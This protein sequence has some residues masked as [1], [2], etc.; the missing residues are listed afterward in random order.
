MDTLLKSVL[1]L[2]QQYQDSGVTITCNAVL[3]KETSLTL[4]WNSSQLPTHTQSGKATSL[5]TS[6]KGK[7]KH[8]SPSQRRRDFRRLQAWKASRKH[9]DVTPGQHT[10]METLSQP[11]CDTIKSEQ[12]VSVNSIT[13]LVTP[14]HIGYQIS[15]QSKDISCQMGNYSKDASTQSKH[16]Q[17]ENGSSQTQNNLTLTSETQTECVKV[18]SHGIQTETSPKQSEATQSETK[19]SILIP[20]GF[21]KCFETRMKA[22][23]SGIYYLANLD[24]V[25]FENYNA[26]VTQDQ[27]LTH[28]IN[29]PTPKYRR[30]ACVKY[31]TVLEDLAQTLEMLVGGLQITAAKEDATFV[32]EFVVKHVE[33]FKETD[34]LTICERYHHLDDIARMILALKEHLKIH[35][36]RKWNFKFMNPLGQ[37]HW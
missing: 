4:K 25:M 21:A 14:K 17:W 26:P 16:V 18:S 31:P 15:R 7:A 3:G 2:V 20:P 27:S 28:H 5:R 34:N 24:R 6:T 9:Q 23:N 32:N 29:L 12:Q 22:L 35:K 30:E 10:R 33:H 37:N 13:N 1:D 11:Q 19:D 8:K 36:C